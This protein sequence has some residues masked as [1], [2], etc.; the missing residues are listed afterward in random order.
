MFAN[1]KKKI[2]YAQLKKRL[3][4]FSRTKAFH[5]FETAKTLGIVYI[6]DE[7][8]TWNLILQVSSQLKEAGIATK[9]VG[10]FHGNQKP[11]YAVEN[12]SM[13][14]CSAD[15]MN[16]Y[17]KPQGVRIDDFMN[18]PLDLLIDLSLHE[19]YSCS[20]IVGLS[21]ASCKVG[22]T[23]INPILENIYDISITTKAPSQNIKAMYLEIAECLMKIKMA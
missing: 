11:L 19:D 23:G 13:D 3:K 15:Q 10:I 20:Y 14:I 21:K 6:L 2:A 1:I 12:L 8:A 22:I 18:T 4:N 5:N 16:W 17:N 9:S 7:E